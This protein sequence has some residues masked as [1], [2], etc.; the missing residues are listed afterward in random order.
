[1]T[2]L[3]SWHLLEDDIFTLAGPGI[4]VSRFSTSVGP[5]VHLLIWHSSLIKGIIYSPLSHLSLPNEQVAPSQPVIYCFIVFLPFIIPAWL[6][7]LARLYVGGGAKVVDYISKCSTFF[8]NTHCLSNLHTSAKTHGS[9]T[10]WL[11][12]SL[13]THI[14]ATQNFRLKTFRKNL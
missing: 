12:T 14:L 13:P 1:M 6:A 10:T 2:S 3:I 4:I 11:W 8:G 9:A 7:E 5:W